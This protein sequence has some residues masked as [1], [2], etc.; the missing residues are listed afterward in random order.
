MAY[1][2]NEELLNRH[3]ATLSQFEKNIASNNWQTHNNHHFDWW[4]FPFDPGRLTASQGDRYNVPTTDIELLKNNPEFVKSL[5]RMATIQMWS[6][7]W[8]M[9]N[10]K[11]LD[12][13]AAEL[14]QRQTICMGHSVRLWKLGSSLITFG[15]HDEFTSVL[16]FVQHIGAEDRD[17]KVSRQL[18]SMTTKW[19]A[20]IVKYA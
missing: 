6:Y 11:V 15:L 14:Q 10:H 4:A 8:D 1:V 12:V 20:L 9:E 7:G 16:K 17:G 19:L 18:L 3:N 13:S 5:A 2:G